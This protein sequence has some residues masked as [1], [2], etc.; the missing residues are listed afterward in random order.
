MSDCPRE[1]PS[2]SEVAPCMLGLVEQYRAGTIVDDI[3]HAVLRL[4]NIAGAAAKAILGNPHVPPLVGDA[5][6]VSGEEH[7][8]E[9]LESA[10]PAPASVGAFPIPPALLLAAA[11][12]LIS[13]LLKQ[14]K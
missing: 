11:Q 3:D 7:A 2:L 9:V 4:W 5:P 1:Y 10:V 6:E 8:I 13:W 12:F 14:K